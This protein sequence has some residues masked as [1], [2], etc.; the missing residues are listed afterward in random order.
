MF[1]LKNIILGSFLKHFLQDVQFEL[2]I[3]D[4][5]LAAFQNDLSSYSAG[6]LRLLENK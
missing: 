1:Y 3:S 4:D 6:Q 2:G 5:K